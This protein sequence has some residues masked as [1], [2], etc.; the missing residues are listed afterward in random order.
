MNLQINVVHNAKGQERFFVS[1]V[2]A[3]GTSYPIRPGKTYKTRA[4]AEA[5]AAYEDF[6]DF[7]DPYCERE[8]E[9]PA[10]ML[11]NLRELKKDLVSLLPDDDIAETLEKLHE[12]TTIFEGAGITPAEI[13]GRR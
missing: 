12:T 7:Y 3:N 1:F 11:Y 6:I 2:Q 5:V 4:I 13:G 8:D 10:E 9:T